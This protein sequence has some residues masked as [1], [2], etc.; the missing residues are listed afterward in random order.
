MANKT[1]TSGGKKNK[2]G[3]D[4]LFWILVLAVI[5]VA[6]FFTQLQISQTYDIAFDAVQT[7][8]NWGIIFIVL[9]LL[10]VI[11]LIWRGNIVSLFRNWI[12]WAVHSVWPSLEG[13]IVLSV[14]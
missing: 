3:L 10:T 7:A 12:I 11:F 8:V 2:S 9:A 4:W 6:I 1:K 5:G 13:N 14:C